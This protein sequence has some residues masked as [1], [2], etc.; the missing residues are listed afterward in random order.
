MDLLLKKIG[1]F[2]DNNYC[3]AILHRTFDMSNI[4]EMP[5]VH[6]IIKGM[7]YPQLQ[8]PTPPIDTTITSDE[9]YQ[10]IFHTRECTSSSPSGHHYGHYQT[11][12]R[13]P[14]LLNC[15]A[16]IA[17]FC[18]QWGISLRHWEKAIQPPIPKDPGIPR[19]N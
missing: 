1:P 6:E 19:I 15:I 2:D 16:S 4:T 5:E 11:M 3:D 12:L 14:T 13:K 8:Q 9:F 7:Q 18:F 17:N 10:M